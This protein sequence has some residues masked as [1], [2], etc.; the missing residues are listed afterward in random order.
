MGAGIG[1]GYYSDFGKITINVGT[2]TAN[3]SKNSAGLGTGYR[4][5][6]SNIVINGGRVSVTGGEWAAGLGSGLVT[7]CGDITVNGGR[8]S[9]TGGQGAPGIGT[10]Y[11]ASSCGNITI[12]SDVT[13]VTA[14]CGKGIMQEENTP[15]QHVE[16]PNS[17]GT[18]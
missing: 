5:S 14:H 15:R 10:G 3:G 12:T 16:Y 1:S 2:I 6:C 13:K 18:G 9:A 8:V 4:S 11:N 17:I 7:K